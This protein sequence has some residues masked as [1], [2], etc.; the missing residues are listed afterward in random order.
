MSKPACEALSKAGEPC[1]AF[2][3]PGA[4]NCWTHS[5]DHVEARQRACSAGG[6][7]ATQLRA[8]E[9]KR[10]KLDTPRALAGFMSTLVHDAL[11]GKVDADLA[12]TIGYLVAVQ[13]KVVEQARQS[14]VERMLAEVRALTADARRRA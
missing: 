8:I 4:R 7:K 3:L 11:E 5:P 9:G 10:R 2:A 13:T 14:D 6:R 1:R 12:R